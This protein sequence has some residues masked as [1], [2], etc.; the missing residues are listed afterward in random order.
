MIKVFDTIGKILYEEIK[1]SHITT[2]VEWRKKKTPAAVQNF[3]KS[4]NGL[5][6]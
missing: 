4:L 3:M 5:F 1:K 6:N 2:G